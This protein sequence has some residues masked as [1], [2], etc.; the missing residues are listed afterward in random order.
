MVVTSG[1]KKT[2]LFSTHETQSS[3]IQSSRGFLCAAGILVDFYCWDR[4][5]FIYHPTLFPPI[6]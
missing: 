5:P 2:N 3:N 6:D 1:A 4:M